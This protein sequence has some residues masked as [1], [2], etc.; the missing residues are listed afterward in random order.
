MKQNGGCF[1]ESMVRLPSERERYACAS[2]LIMHSAFALNDYRPGGLR[3][4]PVESCRDE[5]ETV[6]VCERERERER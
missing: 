4:A 6:C 5:R 2:C 1:G 3:R